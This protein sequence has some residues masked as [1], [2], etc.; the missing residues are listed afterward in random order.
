L[1]LENTFS[2]NE[3]FVQEIVDSILTTFKE[4]P[5]QDEYLNSVLTN[6]IQTAS[7]YSKNA[8]WYKGLLEEIA[9]NYH[10]EAFTDDTG[11]IHENT[12]VSK[13]PELINPKNFLPK[14]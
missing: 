6:W 12:F 9:V 8:E 2:P 1:S 13:L 10:P 11:V 5:N 3:P 14:V 4:S 7:L